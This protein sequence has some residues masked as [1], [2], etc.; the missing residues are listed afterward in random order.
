MRC[1]REGDYRKKKYLND[2]LRPSGTYSIWV[3]AYKPNKSK[4]G[5]KGSLFFGFKDVSHM[6][7]EQLTVSGVLMR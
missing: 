4:M 3:E 6:S 7:P 5:Q 2:R 1:R